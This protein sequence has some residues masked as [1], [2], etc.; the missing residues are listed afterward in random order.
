[1]TSINL[2]KNKQIKI[3]F[4]L[5]STISL[6]FITSLII[7]RQIKLKDAISIPELGIRIHSKEL[8]EDFSYVIS[9]DTKY[10]T[11]SAFLS[12]PSFERS[13][14]QQCSA[15]MAPLGAIILA[16]NPPGTKPSGI[17]MEEPWG[18]F[19][20]KIGDKYLYY[21]NTQYSCGGSEYFT[22]VKSKSALIKSALET[23]EFIK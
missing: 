10:S 18:T 14:G 1:M 16:N 5:I 7:V 13:A 3:F 22:F 9:Q 23:V 20:K 8:K 21:K 6:S 12:T 19:I 15:V 11:T 2:H 17:D 4:L